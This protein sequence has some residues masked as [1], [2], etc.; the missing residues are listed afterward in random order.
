MSR[1]R[2]TVENALGY[3]LFVAAAFGVIAWN[4]REKCLSGIGLLPDLGFACP[5]PVTLVVAVAILSMAV[6]VGAT[7]RALRKSH[8]A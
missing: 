2:R 5:S 8:D 3:A 1:I 4:T 6:F 7:M